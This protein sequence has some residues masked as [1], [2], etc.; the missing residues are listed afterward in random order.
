MAETCSNHLKIV[1]Y[2]DLAYGMINTFMLFLKEM[3][4]VHPEYLEQLQEVVKLP[5]GALT[6]SIEQID[7]L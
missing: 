6:L 4:L 2:Q 1:K 5:E 3:Q 7:E